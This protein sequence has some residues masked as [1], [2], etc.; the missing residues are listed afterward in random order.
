[1]KKTDN[2]DEYVRYRLFEMQDLE[3]KAFHS[4]LMPTVNPEKIIG[5]RTPQ[6]R[7]FAKEFAQ[8]S[9]AKEFLEILPHTYYE[10]NNL[11]GMLIEQIKDYDEC[12][13]YLD[14]FLPYVDNWATCDSLSPPIFKS[15]TAELYNDIKRWLKCRETYTVRF[16]VK[17]L[18]NRY[19]GEKFAP[20]HLDVAASAVREEYYIKMA[21]AW[22]FSTVMTFHF[23]EVCTY[24]QKH[25]LDTWTHNKAIQKAKESYR[26]S[27]EQ[28]RYIEFLKI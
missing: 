6:L 14:K 11:H 3:Y 16:A 17:T 24:L 20:E 5:V 9:D 8:K 28:K 4:K 25:T 13:A 27:A 22:Y 2:I 12:V 21:V 19:S 7:K 23:D 18:M 26:L 10:E 15:H 1:M